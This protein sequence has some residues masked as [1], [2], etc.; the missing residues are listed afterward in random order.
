MLVVEVVATACIP[1]ET[2]HCKTHLPEKRDIVSQAGASW[3]L[4]GGLVEVVG[5]VASQN[6]GFTLFAVLFI[7][8]R[9]SAFKK[10]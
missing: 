7:S 9:R 2:R 5:N 8:M 3:Q 10:Q 6:V 4:S 1:E